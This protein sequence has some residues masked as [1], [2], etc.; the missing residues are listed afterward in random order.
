MSDEDPTQADTAAKEDRKAV[1]KARKAA[2]LRANL[3]RR[4]APQKPH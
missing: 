3:R 2:A 1:E 4:K